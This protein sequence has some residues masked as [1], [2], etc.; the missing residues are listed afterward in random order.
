M[1]VWSSASAANPLLAGTEGTLISVSVTVAPRDLETLLEALARLSFP[2]NP[3]IYHDA[4]VRYVY[5]DGHERTEP[6]TIVEFPAYAGRLVE[7]RAMLEA[8]AFPAD[9]L[10]AA[11]M[12]DDMHAEER[13]EP[14]PAGSPYVSFVRIKHARAAAAH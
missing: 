5:A 2:I 3:Q 1:S 8:Y 7:I 6:T 11:S 4:A 14:A 10:H 12:L 13:A 9:S